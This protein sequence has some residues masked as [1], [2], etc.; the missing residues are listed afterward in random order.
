MPIYNECLIIDVLCHCAQHCYAAR[1]GSCCA[2]P[3]CALRLSAASSLR[4]SRRLCCSE[5]A[6]H[7]AAQVAG[8]SWQQARQCGGLFWCSLVACVA[9]RQ[10]HAVCA[11][12]HAAGSAALHAGS[13]RHAVIVR[14]MGI[15]LHAT[16]IQHT[17]LGRS[18]VGADAAHDRHA[19]DMQRCML[20]AAGPHGAPAVYRVP[21]LPYGVETLHVAPAFI[22]GCVLHAHRTVCCTQGRALMRVLQAS[23]WLPETDGSF[24]ALKHVIPLIV[25]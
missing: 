19:T 10:P 15:A 22:A 17:A 1:G 14:L 2:V 7:P 8:W 20:P 5:A 6:F 12:P 13:L 25:T 11:L 24:D 4:A 21:A 16:R 9:L 23:G 3:Y 18:I